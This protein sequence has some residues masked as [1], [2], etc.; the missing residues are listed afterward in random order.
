MAEIYEVRELF[1]GAYATAVETQIRR[2]LKEHYTANDIKSG[3]R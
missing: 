2:L 3:A 1:V